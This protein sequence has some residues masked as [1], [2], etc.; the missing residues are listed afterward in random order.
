MTKLQPKH[1]L[2][3]YLLITTS[4][5]AQTR[6][7]GA[8]AATLWNAHS[9]A[10]AEG[11]PLAI[12]GEGA[13]RIFPGTAAIGALA[14]TTLNFDS[15]ATSAAPYFVDATT[16]LN[17]HGISVSAITP[18][19]HLNIVN[20]FG[21]Y[22]GLAVHAPS[23]PNTLTQMGSNAPVTF[24]LSFS[25]SLESFSFKRSSLIAATSSGVTFPYWRATAFNA[26]GTQIGPSVGEN[27]FGSFSNVPAATFSMTGPGIA[28]VR[29]DSENRGSG[30]NAVVLDDLGLSY[31]APIVTSFTSTPSAITAGGSSTL[32]WTTANATSVTISGVAGTQAANGSLSVTPASTTTYT[33]TAT[34]AGGTASATATVTVNLSSPK[35][36]SFV[37]NPG[38]ITA[39]QSSTLT[40]TTTNA[41]SVTTSGVA[42]TQA[43][44]GSLSV[45]PASTTTYTLTATG[46]GGTASATATVTVNPSS[47]K[48]VSFVAN[49][50]TVIAGQSTT[51]TW[52]TTNATSVTISGVAG[53]QPANGSL[54]VTPAST[55]TYTLTATGT[56]GTASATAIV[57]V[58]PASPKVVSFVANPATVTTGQTSTLSW[59]TTNAT[60][61]TISGVAGTQPV[62]GS[63]FVFPTVSS[64]YTLTATGAGGIATATTSVNVTSAQ[65]GR[66]RTV[67]PPPSPVIESASAL[68]RSSTGG[69]ITL[70]SGGTV[71]IAAGLLQSDEN[72]LVSLLREPP[73]QPSG[74]I[75][76]VGTPVC[77][78]FSPVTQA[79]PFAPPPDATATGISVV[80]DLSR[81]AIEAVTGA[82]P[83]SELIVPTLP[84]DSRDVFL[85]VPG[86]VD[87]FKRTAT[88][89]FSKGLLDS[90]EVSRS[91]STATVCA[92]L[93]NWSGR[94]SATSLAVTTLAKLPALLRFDGVTWAPI[95]PGE[96][97]DPGRTCVMVHGVLSSVEDAFPAGDCMRH[98]QAQNGCDTVLGFN[99]A[100][101]QSIDQSANELVNALAGRGLHNVVIEGHSLGGVV[102]M[103]AIPRL[104]LAG[105]TIDHFVTL[106]SPMSGTPVAS[107][108]QNLVT[109]LAYKFDSNL[110]G[111]SL[112]QPLTT[113]VNSIGIKD[114][115]IPGSSFLTSA[116]AAFLSST[117]KIPW[118]AAAGNQGQYWETLSAFMCD[119]IPCDGLSTVPSSL[120]SD[121]PTSVVH[122]LP[123][124]PTVHTGLECNDDV[125]N[126]VGKD[127]NPFAPLAG[128]VGVAPDKL[129]FSMSVGGFAPSPQAF[130]ITNSSQQKDSRLTYSVAKTQAWLAL[131]GPLITL[132]PGE[133]TVFNASIAATAGL[134]AGTYSDVIT[135]TDTTSSTF[136]TVPPLTSSPPKTI[137]VSLII[138]GQLSTPTVSSFVAS[139]STIAPGQSS[140]LTW[141]TTNATSVSIN[142]VVEPVSGS[143]LVSPAVTTTY[144]LTATG[145]GGTATA[146]AKVT[147]NSASPTVVSFVANPPTIVAGQSSTL[148]WITTNATSVSISGIAATQGPNGSVSVSPAATSTYTLTAKG[149]GG[150]A[151]AT[152][153]VTLT[154]STTAYYWANWT[155]GSSSQCAD[156][157]GRPN[158]SAGPFCTVG[159]CNA[160][161]TWSHIPLGYSCAV[162]AT[163]TKYFTVTP[164]NSICFKNGV[165]FNK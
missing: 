133:T 104:R 2:S 86:G 153:T 24:T 28:S 53:T 83:F 105:L 85:G 12:A 76:V 16:Y 149:P 31:A 11:K 6:S 39:G 107:N 132:G 143:T 150:T 139:P 89:N 32:S 141:A 159:D 116:R 17:S 49:P 10:I 137:A 164:S 138:T 37:A 122:P 63:V 1:L 106:G 100:W 54:S 29:F 130:T 88:V 60:S 7:T 43:A 20:D 152:T 79:G 4:L 27:N 140:T 66:H 35:V 26:A 146:T 157:Q 46:A 58:N 118:T 9:P 95:G 84:L 70:P 163:Y 87:A 129:S 123:V 114:Q 158:G 144:T 18:G 48:V 21:Y 96:L 55:T 78:A 103:T 111:V 14:L 62:N 148:S 64:T 136:V 160:Y 127:V 94:T 56:G 142:G 68:V 51:L 40:W 97:R 52:T 72:V 38:T 113:F 82:V 5:V 73:R 44:N 145:P 3:L 126:A 67:R 115:L 165:D 121:W 91:G 30:F 50:A 47:P 151:T 59:T 110:T 155:C 65:S 81:T 154:T 8:P 134:K 45:T 125:I 112:L 15:V 161:G 117:P 41:T 23:P 109:L 57:T 93:A 80:L 147:V 156:V 61:V 75:A 98:I 13:S 36:V 77:I 25:P 33:L 74:N 22:N 162:T 90:F 102:A 120:A 124:F 119:F 69:R 108:L 42:G 34:G 128:I 101:Y 135:V 99:Y 131:D 92:E 71:S 19:T